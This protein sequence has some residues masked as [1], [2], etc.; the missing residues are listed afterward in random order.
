MYNTIPNMK[1]TTTQKTCNECGQ[2]FMARDAEIK[3]GNAKFCSL[4][5]TATHFNKQRIPDKEYICKFCG[6]AFTSISS[7]S[8][9]CSKSCK[10]KHYYY[11]QKTSAYIP[12]KVYLQKL[13]CEI[14]GWSICTTDIHHITKVSDGGKNTFENLISLCPNCHRMAHRNLLSKNDLSQIT[15]SRTIPSSALSTEDGI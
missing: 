1:S 9:F 11:K 2:T 3:R 7:T 14:C 6:R 12:V 15:K 4:S 5:C 10:S 8:K 13:S